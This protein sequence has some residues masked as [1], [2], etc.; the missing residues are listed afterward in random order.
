[1]L[2]SQLQSGNVEDLK[3]FLKE[4]I[5]EGTYMV[6]EA[7]ALLGRV[8]AISPPT[9]EEII[10]EPKVTFFV[11]E[12]MEFHIGRFKDNLSVEQAIKEYENLDH[13][14][15]IKGIG[16]QVGDLSWGLVNGKTL[17]LDDLKYVP[18]VVN[19]I[20]VLNAIKTMQNTIKD[21]NV[22][23]KFPEVKKESIMDQLKETKKEAQK[24]SSI[25]KVKAKDKANCHDDI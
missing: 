3:D 19:N 12:D 20:Q 15:G 23:G 10:E 6:P 17:D 21:L 7:S 13:A 25:V 11:A 18:E 16:V 14:R 1:M 22:R 24:Q 2:M 9:K 4:V 5:E 8:E